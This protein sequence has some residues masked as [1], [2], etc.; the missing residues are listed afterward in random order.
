MKDMSGKWISLSMGVVALALLCGCRQEDSPPLADAVRP[1]KVATVS[2]ATADDSGSLVGEVAPQIESNLGFR[3]GGKI[4]E[5]LASVGDVVAA[6]AVL[7]RLDFAQAQNTLRQAQ[8]TVESAT[9]QRDNA[10]QTE[11][12]Q[13]EL[14]ARGFATQAAFDAATAEANVARAN[15]GAA[16]AALADARDGLSYMDLTADAAGVVTAVGAEVGQVVAAGQMVIRLARTDLRDAVFQV[17]ERL[18]QGNSVGSPVRVY[19]LDDPAITAAGKVREIAPAADPITRTFRVKVGL[20]HP[21]DDFRFGSSVRGTIEL[22]GPKVAALPLTAL[23]NDA[24]R[25]ALWVVDRLGRVRI[26]PVVVARYEA[27]RLLVSGGVSEG[28]QVVV[29]GIQRL[30]PGMVVKLTGSGR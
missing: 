20:D 9:A 25:P 23:F 3:T 18:L 8:A 14:L 17:P 28:E 21:S 16:E 1:V 2:F 11:K 30:R 10:E 24:G 15:L 19:L 6:G 13:Q 27:D 29:A 4:S 12:R 5:R 22:A 7:A 26:A